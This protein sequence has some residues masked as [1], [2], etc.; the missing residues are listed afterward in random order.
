[1]SPLVSLIVPAY[2]ASRSIKGTVES[3]L[4]QIHEEL[5]VIV[6]DDSSTDATPQVLSSLT[7]PRLR[8][9]RQTNQ[10]ATVA[11]NT[12]F[13]ESQGAFILF[14]DSDDQLHP[15]SIAAMLQALQGEHPD[16]IATCGW[17]PFLST[18]GDRGSIPTGLHFRSFEEPLE[19]LLTLWN[20]Q[21][22]MGVG[23]YLI[24]RHLVERSGGFTPG[25]RSDDDGDF[26]V[27]ILLM[28]KR[29][30]HTSDACFYYRKGQVKS[31]SRMHQ[32]V[33][34]ES[35][36]KAVQLQVSAVMEK[37]NSPR[38]RLACANRLAHRAYE[39]SLFDLKLGGRCLKQSRE[40]GIATVKPNMTPA[41]GLLRFFLGTTLAL[42]CYGILLGIRGR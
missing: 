28:A 40:Y 38:T 8:V 4:A 42:R 7:D 19:L 5:E 17:V 16:S 25:L 18:P 1:M 36:Y 21:L 12:G 34:L 11:R 39:L 2:N 15:N 24:P 31:Q 3:L 6:V 26:F 29:V 20:H 10:G 9:L 30:C 33:H 32:R 13:Q 41:T 22:M 27:R 14:I 23:C 37:E 35:R